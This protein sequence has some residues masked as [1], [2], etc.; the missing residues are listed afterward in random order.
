[1]GVLGELQLGQAWSLRAPLKPKKEILQG[2][3]LKAGGCFFLTW[4]WK[5]L[6]SV[7]SSS[8]KLKQTKTRNGDTG[9]KKQNSGSHFPVSSCTEFTENSDNNAE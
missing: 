9:E 5:W 3:Y 2:T 7:T 1:M 8:K 6:C 4:H